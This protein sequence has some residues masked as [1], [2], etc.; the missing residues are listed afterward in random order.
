M[1]IKPVNPPQVVGDPTPPMQMVLRATSTVQVVPLDGDW[2]GALSEAR[3]LLMLWAQL[4]AAYC[5]CPPCVKTRAWLAT[6]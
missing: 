2:E 5:S 3:E 1:D 6:H 4:H